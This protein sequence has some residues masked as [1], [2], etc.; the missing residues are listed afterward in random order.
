MKS[1]IEKNMGAIWAKLLD[2][3]KQE[4]KLSNVC[5]PVGLYQ[6]FPSLPKPSAKPH[7]T[8]KPTNFA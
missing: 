4:N 3:M 6:L 5:T 2:S 7:F 1:D 8:Y